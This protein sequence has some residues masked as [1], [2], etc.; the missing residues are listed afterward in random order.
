MLPMSIILHMFPN[1]IPEQTKESFE[2]TMAGTFACHKQYPSSTTTTTSSIKRSNCNGCRGVSKYRYRRRRTK[3]LPGLL[4]LPKSDRISNNRSFI[5]DIF[6][7]Y[8]A[9]RLFPVSNVSRANWKS[10]GQTARNAK[11][12]NQCR[13]LWQRRSDLCQ[14]RL[15]TH[16]EELVSHCRSAFYRMPSMAM[17]RLEIPQRT[18]K[19]SIVFQSTRPRLYLLQSRTL[20][21]S[22]RNR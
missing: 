4:C 20:E 9:R 7:K 8:R 13:M 17:A 22:L 5:I 18:E 21:P 1:V 14:V 3:C 19:N 6:A 2:E 10:E 12:G 11:Y 15:C 16:T